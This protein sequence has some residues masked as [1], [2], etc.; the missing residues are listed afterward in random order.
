MGG[1]ASLTIHK[2]SSERCD[3]DH[4]GMSGNLCKTTTPGANESD[5]CR[6]VWSQCK[7]MNILAVKVAWA[8]RCESQPA[9]KAKSLPVSATTFPTTLSLYIAQGRLRKDIRPLSKLFSKA[10]PLPF[11]KE[12]NINLDYSSCLKHANEMLLGDPWQADQRTQS[13]PL[14]IFIHQS[15]NPAARALKRQAPCLYTHSST[16]QAQRRRRG[17]YMHDHSRFQRDID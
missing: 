14:P 12:I 9:S 4:V 1:V 2:K 5:F 16:R 10:E 15:L 11:E 3:V 8:S 7:Q 17:N 13:F 6:Q